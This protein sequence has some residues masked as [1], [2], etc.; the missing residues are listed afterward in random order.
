MTDRPFNKA[1]GRILPWNLV[2]IGRG[3]LNMADGK[4]KK[5]TLQWQCGLKLQTALKVNSLH[6][7]INSDLGP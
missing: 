7:T 2:D 6:S 1:N 4:K 3:R 5:K